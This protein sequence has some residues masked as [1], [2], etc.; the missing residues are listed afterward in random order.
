MD[1]LLAD[2]LPP[3]E[4]KKDFLDLDKPSEKH[5]IVFKESVFPE[6]KNL[7][8]METFNQNLINKL[9]TNEQSRSSDK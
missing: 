4:F 7:D 5:F 2:G 8:H 9:I 3:Y 1:N 6:N